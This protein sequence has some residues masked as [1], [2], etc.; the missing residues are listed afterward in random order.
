MKKSQFVSR[1]KR[2]VAWDQVPTLDEEDI[3]FLVDLAR[4]RDYYNNLAVDVEEW[5]ATTHYNVGQKIVTTD[6][7]TFVCVVDGVSGDVA[8]DYSRSHVGN[9][10]DG[11]VEWEYAG[12]TNWTPTYDFNR[13]ANEGWGLKAAKAA[14]M[15]SF[16]A[17]GHRMDQDQLIANCERM[18]RRYP[19][20]GSASVDRSSMRVYPIIL[21]VPVYDNE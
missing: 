17:D 4:T 5:E 10:V 16:T 2:A 19:R 20:T 6:H 12:R 14:S 9:Y 8:P 3:D 15:I 13:A 7:E 18:Q 1:L 11:S 21:E